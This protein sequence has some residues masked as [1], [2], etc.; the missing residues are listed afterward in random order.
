MKSFQLCLALGLL[1]AGSTV[2]AESWSLN[3]FR[4]HVLPVLVQVDAEGKVTSVSP[5]IEL[6]PVVDRLLRSSLDEMI[7]KPAMR[8][9]KPVTSQ[10]VINLA[11]KTV[12]HEGGGYDASFAYVSAKPVPSGSWY[13]QHEDGHRL[14]LVNRNG[15]D[16]RRR[17][18]VWRAPSDSY[19]Y[20]PPSTMNQP[21][22]SM[23]TET[24]SRA[25]ARSTGKK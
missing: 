2:H 1:V 8:H 19:R 22:Q 12:P 18:P 16:Q 24:A 5:S 23:P 13:W 15:I 11:L 3:G 4:P 25:P 7:T 17:T 6:S 20:A 10:F 14:A 9:G 21:T